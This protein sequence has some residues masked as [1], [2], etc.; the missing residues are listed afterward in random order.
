M[1]CLSINSIGNKIN[2]TIYIKWSTCEEYKWDLGDTSWAFTKQCIINWKVNYSPKPNI[3]LRL[4]T[5]NVSDW[6]DSWCLRNHESTTISKASSQVLAFNVEVED[7]EGYWC[8]GESSRTPQVKDHRYI[9]HNLSILHL[10]YTS[11][12]AT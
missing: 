8:F 4:Y 9:V 6:E 5:S 3:Y 7:R 10:T 11:M 1:A 12:I 2:S